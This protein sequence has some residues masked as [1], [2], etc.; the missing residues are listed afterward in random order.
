[1]TRNVESI[2]GAVVTAPHQI[3][4]TYTATGGETFISLPFYPVTGFVTINGGVQVPVDNYEIDGNTI[5]LGRTLEPEDVVYCLFDKILSPEDYADGIR[6]YKFQAVGTETSFIPDFAAYGVQ[7]LYI[8]GKFQVP[9]INYSYSSTTGAVSFL[10]GSPAADVWVVAEM[11]V[12]QPNIS[13]LFDRTIQE[14]A[15]TYNIGESQVVMST[16]LSTSLDTKTHIYDV[17]QQKVWGIPSGYLPSGAKVV[18]LSGNTLT[19]D[20]SGSQ[21][22][23]TL[24]PA[25]N[26]SE[27]LAQRVKPALFTKLKS[28]TFTTGAIV[29]QNEALLHSDGMYY[30]NTGTSFPV[31]VAPASAPTASWVA[32]GLLN[33][34]DISDSRAWY[35]PSSTVDNT[36]PLKL[37]MS[38][39][40]SLKTKAT[41]VGDVLVSSCI[42][43]D[44]DLDQSSARIFVSPD[45]DTTVSGGGGA[46]FRCKDVDTVVLTGQSFAT[47]NIGQLSHVQLSGAAF[48][49]TTVGVEGEGD[50][51]RAYFRGTFD[52]YTQ[53]ADL[54]VMDGGT[55]GN[56]P[57]TEALFKFN[58][59]AK[60]TIR[61][62]RAG[63]LIRGGVYVLSA[64]LSG[65]RSLRTCIAIERNNTCLMGGYFD[66]QSTGLVAESYTQLS[67]VTDCSVL[68]VSVPNEAVSSNYAILCY[69]TNRIYV[70]H[71]HAPSGWAL[72]DGNFMRNTVVEDSSGAT[73]GCHAMAWN[74]TVNRCTLTPIIVNSKYQGGI[75]LTGGGLLKVKDIVYTYMGGDRSLD[76]PVSTRGDYG[77]SWEG[78]IDISGV[79]I[80]YA[81]IP[82][83]GQGL[84]I[85]YA[86]GADFGATDLTRTNVY[87]GG[88]RLSIQNVEIQI[89]NASWTASQIVIN[90]AWFQTTYTQTVQYPLEYVVKDFEVTLSG[91]PTNVFTMDPRFPLLVSD[92]SAVQS[93]CRIHFSNVRWP[94]NSI[95]FVGAAASTTYRVT[96]LLTIEE[97]K[98]P[99]YINL[100][101]L[102]ANSV[103]TIRRCTIGNLALGNAN[104]AGEYRLERNVVTGTNFGGSGGGADKAYY[105]EN[106]INTTNAVAVGSVAKYCHGNTAIFGGSITGRSIDEWYSYRDPAVFRTA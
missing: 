28:V 69:A 19:Y 76:H 59:T 36:V 47:S 22:T 104:S 62:L 60:F 8:D 16:N 87:L 15:R 31:I 103:A 79:V 95:M 97:G 30:V 86:N 10:T 1:M 98:S 42:E 68:G 39:M 5:N 84:A 35:A 29:N 74:F 46:V 85:V 54:Y 61:P 41:M 67:Y 53:A 27:D 32:V 43:F 25:F 63:R 38:L 75:S 50:T 6:I 45:S 7:T 4:Y 17:D 64:P 65:S 72:V 70:Q 77:Q 9:D 13:P 66:P 82:T 106:H 100:L 101:A 81:A 24:V 94:N 57:E 2:F 51:N 20:V 73:I 89:L 3:P 99:L 92:P 102:P 44:T 88:K 52:T 26:G 49:N 80:R 96:A 37:F 14:I 12:K 93:T 58:D 11:S 91:L 21:A 83:S 71:C 33:R 18:E 90:P 78:D 105:Y 48:S 34:Y 40:T 55:T 56:H 23:V